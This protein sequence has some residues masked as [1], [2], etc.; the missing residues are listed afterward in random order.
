MLRKLFF[1]VL[2]AGVGAPAAA[3]VTVIG[4]SSARLC[5][6]AADSPLPSSVREIPE[7]DRAL[8]GESLTPHEIV[9]TFVN[10]GILLLR[11]GE[12]DSALKDFDAAIARDP[13]E[14]EAYLNKG[15]L[16]M[17]QPPDPARA[18]PLFEAA[19]RHGTS[20]PAL[21]HYGRGLAQEML[22]NLKEAYLDYQ[23]ATELDPEWPQPREEL[24]RFTVRRN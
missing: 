24:A 10:R 16:L 11:R 13:D 4:N 7:C 17:R 22:G 20:K 8:R 21:A 5:Y 19:I 3:S 23:R 9:A 2:I 14:P 15:A 18:L 12:T 1:A 6:E